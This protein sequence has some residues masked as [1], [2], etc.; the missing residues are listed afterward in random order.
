MKLK[1]PDMAAQEVEHVKSPV[2]PVAGG[3]CQEVQRLA[4]IVEGH[5]RQ[6][7]VFTRI[8]GQAPA[9]R[10]VAKSFEHEITDEQIAVFNRSINDRD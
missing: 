4:K 1:A 6:L 3:C 5:E 9:P 10:Q 2:N 8:F 7:L